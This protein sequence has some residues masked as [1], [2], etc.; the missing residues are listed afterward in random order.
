MSFIGTPLRCGCE[1][2]CLGV[3]RNWGAWDREGEPPLRRGPSGAPA[4]DPQS[5]EMPAKGRL[6]T[7]PASTGRC[8]PAVGISGRVGALARHAQPRAR[9]AGTGRRGGAG[10]AHPK[11]STTLL[12]APQ[13]GPPKS[14]QVEESLV[15]FVAFSRSCNSPNFWLADAEVFPGSCHSVWPRA[16]IR[17]KV[18]TRA[19]RC[20]KDLFTTIAWRVDP[21]TSRGPG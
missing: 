14:N 9:L 4:A 18:V 12:T 6:Q 3:A 11:I 7:L 10:Y 1:G 5:D 20:E 8:G 15:A 21:V 16:R 2:P 19:S 17:A 13:P